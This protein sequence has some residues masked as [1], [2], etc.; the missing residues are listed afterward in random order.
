MK[1]ILLL[2]GMM[3]SVIWVSG[4]ATQTT[5]QPVAR[6]DQSNVQT[7]PAPIKRHIDYKGESLK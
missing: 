5:S 6:N 7:A 4:C 2:I 3:L 1:K